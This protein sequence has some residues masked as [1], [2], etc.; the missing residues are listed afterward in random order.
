LAGVG[1]AM[2]GWFARSL[3]SSDAAG[4]LFAKRDS[5]S[6]VDLIQFVKQ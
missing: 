1:I 3:G 2:N 5:E 4:W 6:L